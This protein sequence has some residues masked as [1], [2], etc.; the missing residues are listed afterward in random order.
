MTY[1]NPEALHQMKADLASWY[2]QAVGEARSA[3]PPGGASVSSAE[4]SGQRP[5]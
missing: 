4:G 2:D 5:N 1:L 3:T